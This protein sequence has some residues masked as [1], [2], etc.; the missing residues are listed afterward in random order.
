MLLKS[1]L[2][3]VMMILLDVL[4]LRLSEKLLANGLVVFH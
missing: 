3:A 4:V 2:Q 1:W